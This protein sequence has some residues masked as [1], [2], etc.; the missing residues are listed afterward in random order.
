MQLWLD[1]P[2]NHKGHPNE[3]LARELMELFTLGIGH[4][5]ETDVKEAA[6]ALT[7]WTV[8]EDEFA[9]RPE[10]HDDGEKV[11][12]GSRRAWDGDQLLEGL[13]EQPATA[14]RLAWRLCEQ[15]CGENVAELNHIAALASRSS[16]S[17]SGHFMG[18]GNDPPQRIVLFRRR[19][20]AGVWRDRR[21]T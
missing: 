3:N 1:A 2:A 4:Y 8:I 21:S 14:E 7:G 11:I 19:I 10:L 12:L 16:D 13:L 5:D 18:S 15:F 9:F 17:Q 20:F 6:R